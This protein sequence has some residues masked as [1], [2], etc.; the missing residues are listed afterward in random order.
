[1]S[2]EVK[3]SSGTPNEA[4]SGDHKETQSVAYSSYQKVL[5]EKKSFQAKVEE[6]T[7]R[8]NEF[9][10]QKL[11]EQ[12]DY[13]K[14][15][16]LRESKINELQAQLKEIAEAKDHAVKENQDTWKLQAFYQELPGKIKKHDY[17]GFVDLDSIVIDPETKRV[18]ETS[19]KEVVGRFMEEYSDLVETKSFKGLP[20]DAPKGAQAKPFNKMSLEEKRAASRA[21]IESIISNSRR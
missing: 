19:V 5:N 12:G 18:D 9:E 20:G 10:T 1:M 15:V 4:A 21:A 17:L 2:E 6:L 7:N 8:I 16:E 13:K 11:N 3:G 14:L